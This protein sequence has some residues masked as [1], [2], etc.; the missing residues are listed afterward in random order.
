VERLV[1]SIVMFSLIAVAVNVDALYTI[2]TV[3]LLLWAMI[4]FETFYVYDERRYR[5][6]HDMEIEIPGS[7]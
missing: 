1:L 5:L 4:A 6:R 7:G 3:N 2:V